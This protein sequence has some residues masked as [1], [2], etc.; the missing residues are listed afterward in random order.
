MT[1]GGGL[2]LASFLLGNK[3]AER[4]LA[5]EATGDEFYSPRLSKV[6]CAYRKRFGVRVGSPFEDH[7]QEGLLSDK[8]DL[9]LIDKEMTYDDHMSY[10]RMVWPQM[11]QDGWLIMDRIYY[12]KPAGRALHDFCRTYNKD[13]SIIKSKYGMGIVRR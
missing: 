4:V 5:F 2:S 11:S 13:P 1:L 10:L 8:W 3:T 7:F 6:R 9:V 12:H